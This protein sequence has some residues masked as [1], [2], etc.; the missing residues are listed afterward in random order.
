ML[1]IAPEAA[2][3]HQFPTA[4]R[5][6]REVVVGKAGG[7]PRLI[8]NVHLFDS[9]ATMEFTALFLAITVVMLVAWRGSRTVALALFGVTLAASVAT[10]LHHATDALKLSF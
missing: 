7:R 5:V 4:H 1:P 8:Y 10:Y 3:L 6:T 2:A 9:R